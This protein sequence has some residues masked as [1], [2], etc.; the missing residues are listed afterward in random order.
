MIR[1]RKLS[2]GLLFVCGVISQNAKARGRLVLATEPVFRVKFEP[3]TTIFKLHSASELWLSIT[4]ISP[5]LQR[6]GVP[7]GDGIG[8]ACE[9]Q[10]YDANGVAIQKWALQQGG[11]V[12]RRA[13]FAWGKSIVGLR[14]PPGKTARRRVALDIIFD[15]KNPGSYLVRAGCWDPGTS[16]LSFTEPVTVTITNP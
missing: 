9:I 8:N 10:M 6:I 3:P 11:I 14:I 12:D 15:V 2:Y 13:N 4:N 1:V 7:P 5:E 16:S